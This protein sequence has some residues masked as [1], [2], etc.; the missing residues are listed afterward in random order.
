MLIPLTVKFIVRA[1]VYC[2]D[3]HNGILNR[4]VLDFVLVVAEIF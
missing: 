2:F 4:S 3:T 1:L